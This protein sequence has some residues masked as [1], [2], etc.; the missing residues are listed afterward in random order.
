MP[1]AQSYEQARRL[2]ERPYR[3]RFVGEEEADHD[4]KA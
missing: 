2:S 3:P 1:L 4:L